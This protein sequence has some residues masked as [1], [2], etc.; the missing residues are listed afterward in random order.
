MKNVIYTLYK[1][2]LLILFLQSMYAWFLWGQIALAILLSAVLTILF[3][4]TTKNV[5]SLKKTNFIPVF[6]IVI[7]QIYVLRDSNTNALISALFRIIIFSV[8]LLLNNKIK[9]ELF[10]F[11]TKAFTILLSVSLFAWILFLIGIPLPNSVTSFNNGQYFFDNYYFFLLNHINPYL[12]IH[13]FSSIFLE[14]GQLGMITSFLLYANKFDIKRK[15]V[16]VLLVATLFTFSLAAYILTLFS[17]TAFVLLKSRKPVFYL[18]IWIGFLVAGYLYFTKFNNGNNPINIAIIERLYIQDGNI[19]GNNRFSSIMD[20]YFDKF[21]KSDDIYTGVGVG[22][23][24]IL[25]LGANAGYKVFIVQYGMIGT[26]LVFLFYFSLVLINRS[27]LTMVFLIVYTLCFVQ[28]AYPLW[29]C[30]LLIFI[31]AMPLLNSLKINS[32]HQKKIGTKYIA[33]V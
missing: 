27:N 14:P 19:V 17:A 2:S 13:R 5:F 7:V 16:W 31:T 20:D 26:M 21:M 3:V 1:F 28:A 9:I 11:F 24:Q 23:Y 6:F 32:F 22:K 18:V 25:K 8:V 15:E 29:E 12:Q 33:A 4:L 30:E 10:H